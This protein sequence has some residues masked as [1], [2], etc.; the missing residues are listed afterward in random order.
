[1]TDLHNY[2]E[3]QAFLKW[4]K[5]IEEWKKQEAK[6]AKLWGRK[7]RDPYERWMNKTIAY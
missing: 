2:E 3:V 5:D 1:M 6:S 4:E 7:P